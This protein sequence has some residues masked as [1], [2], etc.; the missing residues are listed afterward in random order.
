MRAG[1][2]RA[3]IRLR[4]FCHVMSVATKGLDCIDDIVAMLVGGCG[5]EAH[6][7]AAASGSFT[8]AGVVAVVIEERDE[9]G[10]VRVRQDRR[11][12]ADV[13]ER[14]AA[15]VV[16]AAAKAEAAK[17]VRAASPAP[18]A[19]HPLVLVP[20]GLDWTFVGAQAAE[21]ERLAAEE[22]EAAAAKRIAELPAM[23]RAGTQPTRNGNLLHGY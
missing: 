5:T 15:A 7:S 1:G 17:A 9:K 21:A 3:T 8:L 16:A 13:Q 10:R 20:S 22:A 2:A 6:K 4:S 12:T 18:I 11:R 23:L 14:V 19:L